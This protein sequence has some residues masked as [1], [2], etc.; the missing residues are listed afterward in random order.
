MH[1]EGG[2]GE[3]SFQ[4]AGYSCPNSEC[5]GKTFSPPPNKQNK[6]IYLDYAGA[7]SEKAVWGTAEIKGA[8]VTYQLSA[9][10]ST[11]AG[12]FNGVSRSFSW[13]ISFTGRI[14]SYRSRHSLCLNS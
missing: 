10:A 13:L 3:A 9:E 8:F 6:I 12:P 2:V 11:L 7:L 14:L 1:L 5:R 4:P